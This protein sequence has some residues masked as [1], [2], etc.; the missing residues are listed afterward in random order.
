MRPRADVP[1]H[2]LQRRQIGARG[3]PGA[4]AGAARA[5]GASV[6]AAEHV[7]Q[8]GRDA[9]GGEIGRAQALQAQACG[10]A[11]SVHM[12]PV[13][14]KPQ[15]EIGAQVVVHGRVVGNARATGIPGDEGRAAA[16][17]C[18]TVSPGCAR[19]PTSCWWKAPAAPRRSTCASDDI[20]NMG[21]ARASGRAGGTDR[22]H[23]PRRRDRQPRGHARRCSTRRMP[24]SSAASSSTGCAAMRR[25]FADGMRGDR[26][27][28]RMGRRWGWCHSSTWCGACRRRMPQTSRPGRTRGTRAR[29]CGLSCRCCPGSP[30]STISTRCAPS[31]AS[32]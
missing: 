30:I 13:L 20:A 28:H 7:E 4:G 22:R 26:H 29:R 17:A 21:F 19:R 16:P 9:D 27:A 24:H 6:Q 23:R 12:N 32:I 1:G 31:R 14:L 2:R 15:S 5:V 10:V 18:S 3:G 11:P 25:L 8:R